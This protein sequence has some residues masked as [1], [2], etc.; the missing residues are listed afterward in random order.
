M[1]IS[2]KNCRPHLILS[3]LV[4]LLHLLRLDTSSRAKIRNNFVSKPAI[5]NLARAGTLRR[6]LAIPN[7]VNQYQV[8]KAIISGWSDIKSLCTASPISLTTPTYR[9]H[10]QRAIVPNKAFSWLPIARAQSRTASRY[11][12]KADIS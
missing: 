5:H 2:L 8:A 4:F 10:G 3:H 11:F 9:K 6:K 12:L 7:P 1:A